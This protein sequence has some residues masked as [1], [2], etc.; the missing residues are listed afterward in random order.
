MDIAFKNIY[1]KSSACISVCALFQ[2]HVLTIL[3]RISVKYNLKGHHCVWLSL[4]FCLVLCFLC[5][6]SIDLFHNN[7]SSSGEQPEH[8]KLAHEL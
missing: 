4:E 7:F 8:R 3:L 2:K 6:W 1:V 5:L